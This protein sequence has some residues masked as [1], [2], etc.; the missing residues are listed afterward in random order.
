MEGPAHNSAG[1]TVATPLA[2]LVEDYSM[3]TDAAV[4]VSVSH[5]EYYV[6]HEVA[7]EYYALLDVAKSNSSVLLLR[8]SFF[9]HPL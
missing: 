5:A 8:S 4:L 6:V 2:E 9:V 1:T 3:H 7:K